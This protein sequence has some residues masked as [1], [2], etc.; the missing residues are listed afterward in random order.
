M[1]RIVLE[2]TCDRC[3]V[4]QRFEHTSN[5]GGQLMA[6]T[7]IRQMLERHQWETQRVEGASQLLQQD[8]CRA[9]NG[10]IFK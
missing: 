1:I 10:R 3:G 8:I 2:V 6:T 9:C 5:H 7:D 4:I